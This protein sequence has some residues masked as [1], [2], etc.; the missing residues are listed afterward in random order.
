MR[1]FNFNQ[2]FLPIFY[3][4]IKTLCIIFAMQ[5]LVI[6]PHRN[7]QLNFT[8]RTGA[9]VFHDPSLDLCCPSQVGQLGFI[10]Y[11]TLIRPKA[12]SIIIIVITQH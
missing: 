12:Q 5:L 6:K 1:L 9:S 2:A 3:I 7:L 10:Y 4:N 11:K 8:H